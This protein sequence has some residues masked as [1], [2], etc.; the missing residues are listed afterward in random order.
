L[1]LVFIENNRPVTDSLTVAEVFGKEHR[2]VLADIENQLSKLSEAGM[3][4]W[5]VLNFQQ[6]QYQHQ[7]NKQFYPKYN[8]TEDA[9]A[10]VAMSYVTPEAMKMK[11]MFL[12]EFKRL[13][14]GLTKLHIGKLDSY[15]ID[16]PVRR[17]ER[18]IEE[19]KEYEEVEAEKKVVKEQL[20]LAAPKLALYDTAMNA[21]NNFTM[22]RVSKTLGYGRNKLF[23]FLREIKVLRGNN[24]PYQEYIDR[25]YFAVRQYS[26][27]HYTTGIENKTQTLVT[28]K[29][30]AFI[31]ESLVKHGKVTA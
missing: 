4:E 28:P 6:T 9:F 19:R 20:A 11:V 24:L 31:H 7:Q 29:G 27:T 13:R 21:G 30:M 2:N 3:S 5:G 16:D 17:A 1:K 18:W 15:M 22:E 12:E 23:E 26:V 10:I 8:M 14:E 25:G